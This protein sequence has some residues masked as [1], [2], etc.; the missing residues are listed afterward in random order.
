MVLY[1][2][3]PQLQSFAGDFIEF[4]DLQLINNMLSYLINIFLYKNE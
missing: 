3:L 2:G 1:I 4:G